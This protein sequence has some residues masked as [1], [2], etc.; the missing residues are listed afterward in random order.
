MFI[1][2]VSL[3]LAFVLGCF[4]ST[5][6]AQSATEHKE[7]AP[8]CSA[9]V[10]LLSVP[11]IAAWYE[12]R[13][14]TALPFK[15]KDLSRDAYRA[16][17]LKFIPTDSE[18]EC[19]RWMTGQLMTLQENFDGY[20]DEIDALLPES[21]G[22]YRAAYRET[23]EAQLFGDESKLTQAVTKH[24]SSLLQLKAANP[25]AVPKYCAYGEQIWSRTDELAASDF[26][27]AKRNYPL[28]KV[29]DE[30]YD[31]LKEEAFPASSPKTFSAAWVQAALKRALPV[32]LNM[33]AYL[34]LR[35][36][37]QPEELEAECRSRLRL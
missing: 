15:A 3:R 23:M 6:H 20:S 11:T 32:V 24:D 26:D 35:Y 33:R 36:A 18:K 5:A 34:A 29:C 9:Y 19:N 27:D 4:V 12:E 17:L 21:C 7:V 10:D 28:P 16:Q 31:K 14:P 30:G 1:N 37:D 8:A 2:T 13:M 22:Q 25:Q